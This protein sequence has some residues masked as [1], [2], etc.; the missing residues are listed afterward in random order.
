M[1][2]CRRAGSIRTP[3]SQELILFGYFGHVTKNK[4]FSFEEPIP[5]MNRFPWEKFTETYKK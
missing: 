5:K 3:K 4:F 1:N 2:V